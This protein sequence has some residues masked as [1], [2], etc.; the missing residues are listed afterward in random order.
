M[1][2]IYRPYIY[3]YIYKYSMDSKCHKIVP[4]FLMSCERN[5][6][7]IGPL[8]T[9]TRRYLKMPKERLWSKDAE[10]PHSSEFAHKVFIAYV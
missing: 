2:A 7:E 6:C 4:E 5:G 10:F 3:A 8:N 1:W 9:I